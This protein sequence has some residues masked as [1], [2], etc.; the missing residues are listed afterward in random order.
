MIR[1][2]RAEWTKLRT[3][4]G[5]AWLVAAAAVLTV[6]LS[7]LAARVAGCGDVECVVD[8][9]R[10]SLTGVQAGQAVVAVL[11]VLVI[12]NEYGT[13]MIRVT[14]AAVPARLTVLAA[15]AVLVAGSV[16][17]AG[18]VGVL[19]SVLAGR[20]ILPDRGLPAVSLTDGATLRAAVGSVLYL[21]LVGLIALGVAA[22]VRDAATAIGVVLGLLYL[23]P[24]LIGVVSDPGWDRRLRQLAPSDAGLAV[25]HTIGVADLPIGPWQ[26]LGVVSL[27]ALAALVLGGLLLHLRDA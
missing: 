11:A 18:V 26:G 5:P 4:A 14:L 10:T 27:W 17:V 15:K 6:A 19:G 8:P 2:V 3:V 12:G 16:L 21:T 7:A 1:A 20:L 23:F 24:L 13:G 25:Q 9:T 22:A